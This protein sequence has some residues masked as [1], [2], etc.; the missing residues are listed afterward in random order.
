MC[1]DS[2]KQGYKQIFG[3]KNV[4]F[5]ACEVF[6][7]PI[8][9]LY[10]VFME[11]SRSIHGVFICVGYVSVMCRLCVGYVSEHDACEKKKFASIKK[12]QYLCGELTK[13]IVRTANGTN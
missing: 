1:K 8:P 6:F 4:L 5:R 7:L 12:K 13:I 9:M 2:K 10:G 11:Y 3:K